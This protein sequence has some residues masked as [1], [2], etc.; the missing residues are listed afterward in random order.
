M[1]ITT[2]DVISLNGKVAKEGE[3]NDHSW[4]SP[5]DWRHFLELMRKHTLV[6][7]GRGTYET[8]HPQPQLKRLRVVLT[9]HPERYRSQTVPGSIEFMNESPKSLIQR[10]EQAGH[11]E[12]LLVGGRINTE[13]M[14]AG[15]VDEMYV[16]I[17]PVVFGKGQALLEE[18]EFQWKLQLVDVT[19]LNSRGTLLAHYTIDKTATEPSTR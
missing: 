4:T 2:V 13:F 6:V 11:T 14:A 16:T 15:L 5:E 19:Q 10:M 7:M 18:A 17:E 1:R 12:M 8:I 9:H 3:L